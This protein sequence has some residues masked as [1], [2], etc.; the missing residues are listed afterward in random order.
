MHFDLGRVRFPVTALFKE[1]L[2]DTKLSDARNDRKDFSYKMQVEYALDK[3]ILGL[4]N[5]TDTNKRFDTL[6]TT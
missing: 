3:R 2:G 1:G 5:H 4:M 6:N